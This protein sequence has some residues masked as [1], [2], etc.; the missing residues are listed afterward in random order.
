MLNMLFG[1]FAYIFWAQLLATYDILL[2]NCISNLV[3]IYLF[4]LY[5]CLLPLIAPY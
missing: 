2:T 5:H 1:M 4:G 3:F